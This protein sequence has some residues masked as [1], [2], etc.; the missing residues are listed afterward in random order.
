[1][2]HPEWPKCNACNSVTYGV[3]DLCQDM[4]LVLN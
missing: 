2:G 1:M 4:V 3:A